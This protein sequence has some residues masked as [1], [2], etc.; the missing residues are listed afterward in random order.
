MDFKDYKGVLIF[1]VSF[2]LVGIILILALPLFPIGM[3]IWDLICNFFKNNAELLR[4][5]ISMP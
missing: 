3:V 4:D 5:T 2:F 1:M